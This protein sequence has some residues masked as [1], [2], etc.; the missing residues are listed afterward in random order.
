[1]S[2]YRT[3]ACEKGM[4]HRPLIYQKVSMACTSFFGKRSAATYPEARSSRSAYRNEPSTVPTGTHIL[5]SVLVPNMNC[6]F[7]HQRLLIPF[8]VRIVSL[9]AVTQ[10]KVS[11]LTSI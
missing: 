7:I 3:S 9:E 4:A 11:G 5:Q 6:T 1:M 2:K 10:D 8:D